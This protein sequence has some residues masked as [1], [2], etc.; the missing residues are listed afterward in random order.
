MEDK[1]SRSGTV[2]GAV[3]IVNCG[4]LPDLWDTKS[5][6]VDTK[7]ELDETGHNHN[8]IMK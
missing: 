3:E 7:A 5:A 2:S 1:G 4:V 8:R 6:N